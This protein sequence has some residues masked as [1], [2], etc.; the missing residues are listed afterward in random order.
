[1]ILGNGL[2]ANVFTSFKNENQFILFASGVSN[3]KE[4]R[5]EEFDREKK[6]LSNT[7]KK[8]PNKTLIYFSTCAFYDKYFSE[9]LYL[10]HKKDIELW[11]SNYERVGLE[12]IQEYQRYCS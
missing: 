12:S 2:I 8:H 7:I 11:I 6:L 9:S 4:F 5:I 10:N 1:M 3:S